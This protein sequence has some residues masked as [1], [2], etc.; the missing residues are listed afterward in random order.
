VRLLWL[1]VK[2]RLFWFVVVR[3][4]S[5]MSSV[6][7]MSCSGLVSCSVFMLRYLILVSSVV[8]IL[9]IMCMVIV[10]SGGWRCLF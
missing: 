4:S 2:W 1:F 9:F 10:A 8:F 3:C 5:C 7:G 6:V